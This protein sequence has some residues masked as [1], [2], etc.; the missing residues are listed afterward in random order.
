MKYCQ[1]IKKTC[2]SQGFSLKTILLF[3]SEIFA[4]MQVF[5]YLYIIRLT[6]LESNKKKPLQDPKYTRTAG[7]EV[8]TFA[9]LTNGIK[10]FHR[11]FWNQ[12]TEYPSKTNVSTASNV[13]TV[14]NNIKIKIIVVRVQVSTRHQIDFELT[15]QT[16]HIQIRRNRT[17]MGIGKISISQLYGR[18][19]KKNTT[20]IT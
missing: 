12:K 19:S 6:K 3:Y 16:T 4:E 7:R 18:P 17:T 2:Q 11:F 14:N 9:K 1:S 20:K 10:G 15:K 5:T 13:V 8:E